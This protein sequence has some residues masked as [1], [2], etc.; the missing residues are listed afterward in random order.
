MLD[1][2]ISYTMGAGTV[3]L[4]T[5]RMPSPESERTAGSG[6]YDFYECADGR[7][8]SFGGLEP[9][10]FKKFC[11]GIGMPELAD[12]GCNPPNI[13]EVKPMVI[14]RIKEKTL[15]EWMDIFRDLDACV[16][17]VC[18]LKD[19]Y[20]ENPHVRERGMITEVPRFDGKG[21]VKQIANPIRFSAC[22]SR[23]ECTAVPVG[24]HQEEILA[25]LGYSEEERKELRE[26]G[27]FA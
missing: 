11:E 13:A 4:E 19:T 1:G 18:S 25:K 27:V 5:G 6:L 23:Y 10:F 12:G 7:I 8:L 14:R 20:E 24:Y 16:E 26:R 3:F 2:M 17:P 22:E 15:A 21:T 9:Q